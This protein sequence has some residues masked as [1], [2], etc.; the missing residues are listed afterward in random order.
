MNIPKK[1]I[2]RIRSE[3]SPSEMN[4]FRKWQIDALNNQTISL[5]ADIY[6]C[7]ECKNA[8]IIYY[9]SE[10]G[11]EYAAECSCMPIRRML[12]NAH[13][14]GLGT[15][16]NKTFDDYIATE[17]WQIGIKQKAAEF[18][19]DKSDA[20]FT[21]TGQSGAGKTLICSIIARELMFE[22]K[23]DVYYLTWTDFI[24][25]VKRALMSDTAKEASKEIEKAKQTEVL[26]IDELL[27]IYTSADLKYLIEIINYRYTKRLKTIITSELST[28][29]LCDI[30]E[31]TF[32]RMIEMSNQKG[33]Y[34]FIAKDRSK[35]QR[36]S[37]IRNFGEYA[38]TLPT[39]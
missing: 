16:I 13:K 35:N 23:K 9:P 25:K 19:R 24:G 22:Q 17:A 29:E 26:F 1:L 3:Y 31:A 36:L 33:Y 32:G 15:Y 39:V 5:N 37:S 14:N 12:E 4:N 28:Q 7:P 6:N 20:W 21:I 38:P 18:V 27:K 34:I 10:N 11:V 8:G 2:N 30:D